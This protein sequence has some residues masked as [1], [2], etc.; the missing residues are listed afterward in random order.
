MAEANHAP[1][2]GQFPPAS[3]ATAEELRPARDQLDQ[4]RAQPADDLG[5]GR[6]E[7]VP[8]VNHQPQRHR[9]VVDGDLPQTRGAQGDHGHRAGIDGVDLAAPRPLANTRARRTLTDPWLGPP[10]LS[11]RK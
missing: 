4:L 11:P 6:T 2:T 8:A 7:P 5:V 1:C 3:T 10:I 9:G